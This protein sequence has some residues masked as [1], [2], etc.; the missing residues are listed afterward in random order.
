MTELAVENITSN[1][2]YVCGD[3]LTDWENGYCIM[4]EPDEYDFE[5]EEY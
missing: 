4:C 2:C 5:G 3:L 1:K